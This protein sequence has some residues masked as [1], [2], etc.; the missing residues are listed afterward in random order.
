MTNLIRWN[1]FRDVLTLHDLTR[2]L[3]EPYVRLT[4]PDGGAG[5]LPPVDIHEEADRVVLR[6]E[7]PGVNREDVDVQVENGTLTI[8]GEKK[9]EK[10]VNSEGAS[11]V[12]RF[13]GSFSR[14]F[15]LPA[16]V[17]AERVTATCKDGVLEVA[18]PKSDA[19]K[20]R[21]VKILAA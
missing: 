11:R 20:P 19:A 15:A 14:S 4:P 21:K 9:Q 6:A 13:Y 5:W 18:L 17:D 12:E 2:D 7:I 10:Q 8:R 16:S 3:F 1:P